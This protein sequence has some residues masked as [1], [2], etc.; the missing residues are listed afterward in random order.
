MR[1]AIATVSWLLVA[2][3]ARTHAQTTSPSQV[4]TAVF[5]AEAAGNWRRLL[6]L[7]HPD[8]LEAFK[9]QQVQMARMEEETANMDP[10]ALG[11]TPEQAKQFRDM[12]DAPSSLLRYVFRVRS[13]AQ[14]EALPAD[15]LVA[16]FLAIKNRPLVRDGRPVGRTLH[17][18]VL[19]E[20]YEDSVTVHVVFRATYP[21]D[22]VA[23]AKTS[24]DWAGQEAERTWADL[25]TLRKT[26][27]GWRAML[28]GDIL[29]TGS[30]GYA[31]GYDSDDLG[32]TK[33]P[34]P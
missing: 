33:A 5:A 15:T 31:I 1:S 13:A 9:R 25:L 34:P 32:P 17:R 3:A 20:V 6:A 8:A 2:I 7:T 30:G 4:A 10:A 26:A 18:S 23:A 24:P 21:H 27:D 29:E 19:G 28:N 11:M 14:L 16:R 22:S 12:R